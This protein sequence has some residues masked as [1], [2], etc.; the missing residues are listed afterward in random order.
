MAHW[1]VHKSSCEKRAA[2]IWTLVV[3]PLRMIASHEDDG[4]SA[5]RPWG[6]VLGSRRPQRWTPPEDAPPGAE[7]P[8]GSEDWA[9]MDQ[10]VWRRHE[11]PTARVAASFI[12]RIA[13]TRGVLRGGGGGGGEG[14]RD[15]ISAVRGERAF[16]FH[17]HHHHH[18]FFFS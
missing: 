3:N 10:L 14:S 11:P 16:F 9:L 13:A 4:V 18:F 5:V 8:E 12:T 15:A 7:P 2:G 6:L 1:R 17:H